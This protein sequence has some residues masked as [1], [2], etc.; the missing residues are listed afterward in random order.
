ML[1]AHFCGRRALCT[2]MRAPERLRESPLAATD[3]SIRDRI[4]IVRRGSAHARCLPL[5]TVAR[6]RSQHENKS[7]SDKH[8]RLRVAR[9]LACLVADSLLTVPRCPR[10]GALLLRRSPVGFRAERRLLG[11]WRVRRVGERFI[12]VRA[13]RRARLPNEARA[14]RECWPSRS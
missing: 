6:R 3:P 2:A 4:T 14:P 10:P 11:V 13:Q 12:C 5:T 9:P 7:R 1:D 8:A